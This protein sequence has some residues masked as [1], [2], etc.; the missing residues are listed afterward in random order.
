MMKENLNRVKKESKVIGIFDSGCG[1]LTVLRAVQKKYPHDSY[2]YVGDLARLPYGTK[3]PET[4]KNY[5]LSLTRLL[6]NYPLKA[7]V[8]ACNTAS[9]YGAEAVRHLCHPSVPV[10]EM[11]TP[12]ARAAVAA[13]HN[14]HISV[15]ATQG[16][17]SNKAYSR[18]IHSIAP[19]LTVT[20]TACQVLVALAEE[21]WVKDTIAQDT[22]KRYL[23]PIFDTS[24]APDTLILGCTHFPLF[25]DVLRGY[26]GEGVTII[27][28]GE[29]VAAQLSLPS[30]AQGDG[31]TQFLVTDTPALFLKKAYRFLGRDILPDC[32]SYVDIA[33]YT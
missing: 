9:T 23:D 22:V 21:G 15:I 19:Q 4:V 29:A 8:I 2:V 30:E 28:S 16:T 18:A 6:Q 24:N 27:N 3:S 5:C 26:V 12:A 17:V 1:G 7:L 11:I 14:A 33:D 10:I 25:E 20:E 31:L 32:V 13:T